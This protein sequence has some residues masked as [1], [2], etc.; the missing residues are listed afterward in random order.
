ME[1][2]NQNNYHAV[3]KASLGQQMFVFGA[4]PSKVV[5]KPTAPIA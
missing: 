2:S 4:V 5:M 1:N 3:A